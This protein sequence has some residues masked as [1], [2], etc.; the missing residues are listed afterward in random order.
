MRDIFHFSDW[1]AQ[2]EEEKSYFN[3]RSR[4]GRWSLTLH[5]GN[6][7]QEIMVVK[8]RKEHRE[9]DTSPCHGPPNTSQ[10]LQFF[11]RLNS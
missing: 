4:S 2:L 5:P 10:Q 7:G 9:S 8:F 11:N 3:T 1:K 6:Q